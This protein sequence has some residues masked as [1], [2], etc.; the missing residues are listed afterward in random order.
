MTTVQFETPE[1]ITVVYRLA[2][3]GS[4]FL[5]YLFDALLIFF[6]FV[7]IGLVLLV[8]GLAFPEVLTEPVMYATSL[9]FIVAFG[10]AYIVYFGVFEWFTNGHTPGKRL[11]RIRVVMEEGFSLTFTGVV[12]RNVFRVLDTIPLFWIVPLVS[13]KFQ[14]FGDMV[15]DT[16]VVGD[17]P[18]PTHAV[19]EA[20]AL[21]RP[22]EARHTFG[23][24]SLNRLR[25]ID[26]RAVETF[27]ERRA[28]LHP[29]HRAALAERLARAL[30]LR[31]DLT[32]PETG[33]DREV[34]LEDLLAA[35]ARREA[36]ELG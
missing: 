4:R 16:L 26:V 34:F 15:A 27:L 28:R 20:L 17:A 33:A 36:R 29:G 6:G 19:R 18:A 1:N 21:R 24:E 8:L 12:I 3:P 10:F 25:D 7:L 35:Y 31:L 32:P 13:A 11:A 22:E 2:G 9:V 30:A 5:A 14:R 23:A